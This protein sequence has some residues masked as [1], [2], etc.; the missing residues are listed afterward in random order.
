MIKS[1][2]WLARGSPPMHFSER[3]RRTGPPSRRAHRW[4]SQ[5]TRSIHRH[6]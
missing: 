2:L 5:H 3:W 6:I 1:P 4:A